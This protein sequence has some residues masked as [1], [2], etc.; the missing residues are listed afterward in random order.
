[1]VDSSGPISNLADLAK[2]AGVSVSTV[3]RA[4]AGNVIISAETRERITELARAHGFRPN[5]LARNL[6]LKRTHAIGVVLPLGH[7]VGQHL[8]DP[9]FLT[10]LGHLADAVTERGYDLLLSRVIPADD[11]WLDQQVDSGRTDGLIVIGQ[12]DQAAVLDRVAAR[13]RP[14]VVWG[15]SLAGQVHC[16]VGTDNRL[17]GAMAARRL[18]E[19]GRRRLAFLGSPEA[20]EIGQRHAGFAQACAAAGIT[21][22]TVPVHLT[23]DLAYP[24]IA[25]RLAQG[26]PP[27]GIFTASDVVAMAALRALGEAGLR[28]PD[29]VAVIGFDDVPLAAH[30]GPPLTTIRQDT[31]RGAGLLVDLLLRRLGGEAAESL[32]LPPELVVRGSA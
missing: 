32:V 15:A 25:E 23:A 6:R 11:D 5:Q 28:V 21:V 27:D 17:G 8:S 14:L 26:A 31:A 24:A 16:S 3:S 29:D 9:F 1:M 12:S 7:E 2:V 22:E 10:M 18:I 4:L 30:T 20:P 13:Y 19:T